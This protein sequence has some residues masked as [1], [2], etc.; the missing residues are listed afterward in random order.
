VQFLL[1]IISLHMEVVWMSLD[2][3]L[4]A[5]YLLDQFLFSVYDLLFLLFSLRFLGFLSF[6]QL[7]LLSLLL[8]LL[9]PVHFAECE[10]CK[11]CATFSR[12]FASFSHE[13]LR[14]LQEPDSVEDVLVE[15]D[16][17]FHHVNFVHLL[18]VVSD[19]VAHLQAVVERLLLDEHDI[20]VAKLLVVE[21]HIAVEGCYFLLI[22]AEFH[23]VEA[24][25]YKI[26][27]KVLAESL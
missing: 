25:R 4:L 7:L 22:I 1:A 12:D 19:L 6:N 26:E 11:K 8:L 10:V 23:W 9:D 13:E 27:G 14:R 21:D 24:W 16:T 17:H 18:Q 3:E 2:E 15:V 20:I 5:R